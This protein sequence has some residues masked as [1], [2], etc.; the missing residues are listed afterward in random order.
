MTR[1][2]PPVATR[3]LVKSCGD[4]LVISMTCSA[5]GC[6]KKAVA[7][8]EFQGNGYCTRGC[9]NIAWIE[10]HLKVPSGKDV[11]KPVI[12]RDW[13]KDDLH[14]LYDTPT[15]MFI[16][17][18][19]RKNAKTAKAAFI[20]LLHLCG[21]E[22]IVNTEIYSTAMSRDQAAIIFGLA[23]KM[24]RMSHDLDDA[25]TIR[26]TNKELLCPDRG[27]FYKALS[28]DG[29]TTVGLSPAV[30]IH[31]ELGM[32]S[33]PSHFLFEACETA[34]GAHDHPLSVVISTQAATDGDLLSILIDDALEGTD[35]AIK[36]RLRTAPEDMDP[37]AEETVRMANPAFGDF[38]NEKETMRM[39]ENAR[40][41]PSRENHYRNLVLNQRVEAYSPFITKSTWATCGDVPVFQGPAYG[42]LD[43]SE[44]NDL[45]SF[46]LMFSNGGKFH[47][48]SH[49]WL[50]GE[51]L[52]E[53]SRQDRVPYD[54]WAKEG[55]LHTTPGKSIE[56]EYVAEQIVAL[57]NK[58]DIRKV[59]FDR[60][61]MRHLKPWLIKAGMSEALLEERFQDFG[62]GF[63]S[64][65]PALRTLESLILNEKICHGN[66]P[67]LTMCAANAVVKMD[68]AGNRKLDKK[69][70]RGR[71]DGMVA[72][73]MASSI[74]SENQGK[75]STI[76]VELEEIMEAAY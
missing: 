42:G 27:T 67:L 62:Q 75:N 1:R 16:D 8:W 28:A 48:Q 51:G 65:S 73:A 49:F 59:A 14:Y 33:G 50:P 43:L 22:S 34:V 18:V 53:R 29:R 20:L 6:K 41:M 38:Q 35:P 46:K 10:K 37:F 66:H 12:L 17:S 56:Y 52:E 57:F 45:T 15:R 40:R 60:F 69:R 25:I 11:G 5:S 32:V 31:D 23:S 3:R 54:V 36:V 70:S 74:A 39:A 9:R 26:D 68:E 64:M 76:P 13:Q 71:I 30:I 19:G 7:K 44:V 2:K 47:V 58:H 55:H 21:P 63:V 72:L 24:I 4:N 61:N